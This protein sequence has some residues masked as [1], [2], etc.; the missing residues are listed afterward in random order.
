[1]LDV[2][3]RANPVLLAKQMA[4]VDLLS[5]GRLTAGLGLGGWPEDFAASDV[6]T[7]GAG[8]R[9][10]STLATLRQVWAGDLAGQ[11][12]PTHRLPEGRPALLF[13]GLV[14]AAH[15]RA[16]TEGQ[17]WVAPLMGLPILEQ[18]AA[19]VRSAWA[20][21]GRPGEP[22]IVTGRYFSL[23][24]DAG[25]GAAADAYLRHYYGDEYFGVARA[26]TPTS[27]AQLDDELDRLAAA[28]VTDVVLYPC[29][30]DLDQV[31]LLADA[32]GPRLALDQSPDRRRTNGLD[33]SASR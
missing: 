2:G 23:G 20:D 30:P 7:A 17:G 27:P 25:A 1:M 9:L 15:V 31:G 33:V 12:G 4:S 8:A 11:G 24:P 32:L 3:W 22:R 28:G 18:G 16:A 6:P 26:D 19:A 29:S 10:R 14:A 5:G 21:A 13:G